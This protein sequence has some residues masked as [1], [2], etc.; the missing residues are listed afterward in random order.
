MSHVS[1]Y[2]WRPPL[3]IPSYALTQIRVLCPFLDSYC[4]PHIWKGVPTGMYIYARQWYSGS[5]IYTVVIFC[6]LV[7]KGKV[8]LRTKPGVI[9]VR[10]K[11]K[12]GSLYN[13][14]DSWRLYPR[15]TMD[16]RKIEYNG[17]DNIRGISPLPEDTKDDGKHLT[18][19]LMVIFHVQLAVWFQIL[20][21]KQCKIIHL[22]L[23]AVGN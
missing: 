15:N 4:R 16:R 9:W 17:K 18:E 19:L 8:L 3:L 21:Q 11:Y 22:I 7:H 12:T 1:H 13:I 2:N 10:C 23:V 20:L 5:R 6:T 14:H